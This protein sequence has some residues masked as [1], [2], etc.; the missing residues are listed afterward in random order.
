MLRYEQLEIA[1][2]NETSYSEVERKRRRTVALQ[3]ALSEDERAMSKL[4]GD[5][6][7]DKPQEEEEKE[8]ADTGD[9]KS[10]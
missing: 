3:A 6:S 7:E 1:L 9:N 2:A 8:N 10:A 5:N 4:I